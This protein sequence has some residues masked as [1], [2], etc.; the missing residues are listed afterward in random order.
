MRLA[1]KKRWWGGAIGAVGGLLDT[2]IFL[3]LGVN[4]TLAGRDLTLPVAI[5]LSA[6]FA[7][8]CFLIGHFMDARAQA[9]EDAVTISRQMRD[10]ETSQRA[11]AQNEK[12]AAIGRL[13]AGVAHEVR[14]PLGVIRASASM[15]QESFDPDDEAHRAWRREWN[16]RAGRRLIAPISPR[17]EVEWAL[18]Q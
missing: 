12:L 14:N 7:V 18:A 17:R 6:N 8:L 16:T 3:Q 2:A 11:A 5:F 4:F 13:A 15:V 9:R 1:G 10:L